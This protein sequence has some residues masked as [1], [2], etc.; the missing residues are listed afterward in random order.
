MTR[1][2]QVTGVRVGSTVRRLGQL[3]NGPEESKLARGCHSQ[4]SFP[5]KNAQ[6]IVAPRAVSPASLAGYLVFWEVFRQ[7]SF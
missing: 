7:G 1:P 6:S 3:S 4:K 5:G 2:G